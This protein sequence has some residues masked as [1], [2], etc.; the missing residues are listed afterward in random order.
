MIIFGLIVAFLILAGLI[1]WL[2]RADSK[3][4]PPTGKLAFVKD[5]AGTLQS[6]FTIGAIIAAGWWFYANR[7][8]KP[9]IKIEHIVSQRGDRGEPGSI[10]VGV[11][12][13]VTNIGNVHVHL[14]PDGKVEV[15][16]CN[17]G[18]RML[19]TD[20]P[21]E[22][23]LEPGESDQIVF[24][25]LLVPSAVRTLEVRTELAAPEG[26]KWVYRSL[27]DLDATTTGKESSS[28]SSGNDTSTTLKVPQTLQP[29]TH[30]P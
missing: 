24:S 10:F 16:E 28:S 11:E 8:N 5:A 23:E 27:V 19:E 13:K 9:R 3:S 22:V 30:T 14:S 18:S 20:P 17:P 15:A 12:V 7:Q 2:Y 26:F 1:G 25:K 21:T 29:T 4:T 6:L